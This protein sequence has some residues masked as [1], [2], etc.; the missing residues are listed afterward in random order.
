MA[1]ITGA[2][3]TSVAA[4]ATADYR[5]RPLDGTLVNGL[6]LLQ[7]LPSLDLSQKATFH[8]EPIPRAREVSRAA[9]EKLSKLKFPR[10]LEAALHDRAPKRGSK[11][12]FLSLKK[13][14][15]RCEV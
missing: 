3:T 9:S 11:V 5:S 13:F 7:F 10:A 1:T 4:S 2:T 14:L 6:R 12:R 15:K 8:R